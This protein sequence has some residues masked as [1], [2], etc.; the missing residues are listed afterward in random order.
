MRRCWE[1]STPDTLTSVSKVALLLQYQ[2]KYEAAEEIDRRALD[3][4]EKVLGKEHPNTLTSVV[5]LILRLVSC[6]SSGSGNYRQTAL[7]TDMFSN[8]ATRSNE[9]A[10]SYGH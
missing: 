10:M 6:C 8:P 5:T 4:C 2:G 3:G 7:G 1:R 9:S